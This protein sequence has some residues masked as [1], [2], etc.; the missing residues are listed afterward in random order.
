MR[1][2][3]EA[4]GA[5]RLLASPH[6]QRKHKAPLATPRWDV[7][8]PR[9]K[10][11][12]TKKLARFVRQMRPQRGEACSGPIVNRRRKLTPDRRAILTPT[13][14]DVAPLSPE[15]WSEAE[16][17]RAQRRAPFFAAARGS[18]AGGSAPAQLRC[19]KR[20]LSLPVSMMSQW[21]VS[22]SSSAVVIFGSPNTEAHSA[23]VRLV[24][25]MIEV[26]S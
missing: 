4:T 1:R 3:F 25:T 17:R 15:L 5:G 20:Q 19:L 22:R 26:R 13:W 8:R 11:P 12:R 14:R 6:I 23:K 21:C 7:A 16:Q 10:G 9:A 2:P 24:V 18:R